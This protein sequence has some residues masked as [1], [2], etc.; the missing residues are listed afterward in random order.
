MTELYG[1]LFPLNNILSHINLIPPL[2]R[3]FIMQKTLI[4]CCWVYLGWALMKPHTPTSRLSQLPLLFLRVQQA[5]VRQSTRDRDNK[6]RLEAQQKEGFIHWSGE[7]RCCW[8]Q[9]GDKHQR[10]EQKKIK[11]AHKYQHLWSRN[12][13]L[14][15]PGVLFLGGW[16]RGPTDLLYST[17][18]EGHLWPLHWKARPDMMSVSFG[19]SFRSYIA[20]IQNWKGLFVVP[21][22]IYPLASV[23]LHGKKD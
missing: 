21:R 22:P 20:A 7:K 13:S 11:F 14:L 18:S 19:F 9:N 5:L 12:L 23:A 8:R 3:D 10:N 1:T 2:G 15:T 6:M 17:L 16:C 4:H